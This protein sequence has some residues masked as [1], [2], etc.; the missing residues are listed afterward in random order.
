ML[1]PP[2][3]TTSHRQLGRDQLGL[4][5]LSLWHVAIH[6]SLLTTKLRRKRGKSSAKAS[7]TCLRVASPCLSEVPKVAPQLGSSF[8]KERLGLGSGL[9]LIIED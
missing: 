6:L 4:P 3:I 1:F 8:N 7:Y 9:L 5:A 2:H